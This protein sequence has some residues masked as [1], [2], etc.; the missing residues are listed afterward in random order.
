MADLGARS[1]R[2]GGYADTSGPHVRVMHSTGDP[3]VPVEVAR[4]TWLR[5]RL[6]SA[7]SGCQPVLVMPVLAWLTSVAPSTG[8]SVGGVC[9]CGHLSLS[10]AGAGAR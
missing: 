9:Q 4:N 2:P 1:T 6:R 10:R 8:S 3:V 5:G 7:A